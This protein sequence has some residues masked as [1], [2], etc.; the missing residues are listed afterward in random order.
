LGSSPSEVAA[1]AVEED[2]LYAL[3]YCGLNSF[4]GYGAAW[5]IMSPDDGWP[6]AEWA[7]TKA[8]ELDDQLADA[9]LDLAALKMVYYLDW[10]GTGREAKRAIELSPGFDEI[11]YMYSFFIT[12]ARVR[13]ASPERPFESGNV[14]TAG[15]TEPV[16]AMALICSSPTSYSPTHR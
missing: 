5:G 14:A 1:S 13:T 3:G 7:V 11:N 8:L 4:Y 9:H 2:P 12:G 10:V 6:K 16:Q 15:A